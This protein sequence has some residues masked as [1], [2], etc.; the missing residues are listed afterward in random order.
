MAWNSVSFQSKYLVPF[1]HL[2]QHSLG[3]LSVDELVS[4]TRL[5][6]FLQAQSYESR[7]INYLNQFWGYE[8]MKRNNLY[9]MK[10]LKD[11]TNLI[12][13]YESV[14]KCNF[15][16][17]FFH[18]VINSCGKAEVDAFIDVSDDFCIRYFMASDKYKLCSRLYKSKKDEDF[19]TLFNDE[20]E[21]L[22]LIQRSEPKL[23]RAIDFNDE[24][25][26]YMAQLDQIRLWV[27]KIDVI[28]RYHF[29]LSSKMAPKKKLQVH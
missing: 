27:A 19:S 14:S 8:P 20:L 3:Q 1:A 6:A 9:N 5:A 25:V 24:N 4:M 11:F 7:I 10:F 26:T 16:F 23:S 17:P 2:S 22:Q 21:Q 12:D 29:V 18:D 28:L 13:E 15:G